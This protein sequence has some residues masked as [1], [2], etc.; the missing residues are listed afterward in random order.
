MMMPDF[1]Q[2]LGWSVMRV[3]GLTKTAGRVELEDARSSQV[4]E[5][6]CNV[7]LRAPMKAPLCKNKEEGWG[8]RGLG[9]WP[10]RCLSQTLSERKERMFRLFSIGI[11]ILR[12]FHRWGGLYI[13]NVYC[14]NLRVAR[15]LS[16]WMRYF[17]PLSNEILK[18][19]RLSRIIPLSYLMRPDLYRISGY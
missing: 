2:E 19:K 7:D 16:Y 14:S 3:V 17:L 4:L 13:Y 10:L 15:I 18:E 5:D 9:P 11:Q 8:R 6:G 1:R 12:T